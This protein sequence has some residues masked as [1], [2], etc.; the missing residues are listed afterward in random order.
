MVVNSTEEAGADY[1]MKAE[2]ETEM[3]MEEGRKTERNEEDKKRTA[4]GFRAWILGILAAALV[5]FAAIAALVIYVDP[6]FQYHKPLAD[7]PY[8]IDNQLSQNPGMA[9]NWEYDSVILGSSM[10]VN[11]NTDWFME[12][13]G[14]KTA[15]LSY[16]GAYPKDQAN[17]MKLIFEN[18]PK[19]KTVYLG[20]DIPAYSSGTEETKYPIPAYLYDDNYTNDISYLL[21]KDVLLNYILRP[22]ADPK[23]KTDIPTM[24]SLWWT[25]EYFNKGYV[26][27]HYE[28]P[29]LVEEEVEREYFLPNLKNNLDSN[30]CPYIEGNPDTEFIIF[31]PPYSILYW[32]GV[33]RENKLEA[34]LAEYE[35]AAERLLTYE[36]VRVF[37]FSDQEDIMEELNHYADY[38]HYHKSINRYMAESFLSGACELKNTQDLQKR[39]DKLRKIAVE[40]DYD[41]IFEP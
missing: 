37:M 2:N 41:S 34:T 6:F 4:G 17:I 19:V 3:K 14:Q 27:E 12:L 13:F 18:N 23:D 10:T 32:Y 33:N 35:Y 30:I 26:L 40:Y 28:A 5:V 9:K 25:D 29:E 31:Y 20:V 38:D 36:N 24:Y 22:L 1:D 8:V 39:M 16:N 11:F 21:N 15:K 7:F